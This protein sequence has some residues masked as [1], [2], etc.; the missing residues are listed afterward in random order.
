MGSQPPLLRQLHKIS[1]IVSRPL[2][3]NLATVL[4][5][6]VDMIE[7]CLVDLPQVVALPQGFVAWL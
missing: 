7:G 1:Q 2:A 3:V 4:G 5:R 6:K